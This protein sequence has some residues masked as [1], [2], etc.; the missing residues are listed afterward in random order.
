MKIM[1]ADDEANIRELIH[2]LLVEEG[3]DCCI[4]SDGTEALEMFLVESPDLLILDIMMPGVN[5]FDVCAQLRSQGVSAPIIFL[6]AKGDIVD[7]SVGFKAGADDYLVKPFAPK[8]LLLRIEALLRRRK[9]TGK[10]TSAEAIRGRL[11]FPGLVIDAMARVVYAQGKRVEL[12]P[13]EF[14][15]LYMLACNEGKAF[16]RDQIIEDVWGP[17]YVNASSSIS[18]LIRRIRTKIEVVPSNPRYIRTIWHVGYCFHGT[19][20][21]ES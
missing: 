11:E 17:E 4:A 18:V 14:H 2:H 15:I 7:K 10:N 21:D 19:E 8:E 13:K 5:G 16:T 1:L 20:N 3:Y 12:T 9:S 6:T